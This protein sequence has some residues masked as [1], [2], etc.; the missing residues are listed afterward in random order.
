[1]AMR[2]AFRNAGIHVPDEP[3]SENMTT[4]SKTCAN[5][6]KTFNPRLPSHKRCN[7]CHRHVTRA[8]SNTQRSRRSDA[9]AGNDE[10]PKFSESY[11]AKDNKGRPYLLPQFVSKEKV[12]AMAIHLATDRPGLTTGQAR[13]FFNHCRD[14]ERNLKFGESWERV[15]AKFESLSVHAQNAANTRPPKIPKGF[16]IFIDDN[17]RRVTSAE[18]PE[19]AFLDGFL[20]HFEALIGYG[21]KHM[22][23]R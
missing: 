15:S 2:E 11:F 16:Q 1:M 21:S 23:D 4:D 12:D 22:R 10:I 7:D 9:Q 18:E 5:C 8:S 19:R 20:P 6:G 3:G 17:V 14:I 13:R